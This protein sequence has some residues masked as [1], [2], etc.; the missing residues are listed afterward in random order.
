MTP[1][2][3]IGLVIIAINV[4][5]SI[6]GFNNHIFF[7]RF[8]FEVDKILIEKQYYRLF[9]SSFLHVSWP[10]LIFNM[11][12]LYAFSDFLE[13]GFGSLPFLIIYFASMLGG[14]LLALFIHRHH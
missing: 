8:K 6:R 12:S 3:Y 10:H 7:D 5:V 14:D 1:T 2:G 4:L 11:I 9:T 13:L